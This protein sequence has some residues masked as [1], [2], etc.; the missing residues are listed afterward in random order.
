MADALRARCAPAARLPPVPE[1]PCGRGALRRARVARVV[2]GHAS[3]SP[4]GDELTARQQRA[5]VAR[6][7]RA[8]RLGARVGGAAAPLLHGPRCA[9]RELA[10]RPP[11]APAHFR[12]AARAARPHRACGHSSGSAPLRCVASLARRVVA[13][14]PPPAVLLAASLGSAAYGA[15][16]LA[17]VA[18]LDGALSATLVATVVRHPRHVNRT[19]PPLPYTH[20]LCAVKHIVGLSHRTALALR[21]R[22]SPARASAAP[23]P[24]ARPARRRRFSARSTSP[25]P[26]RS[27]SPS[28]PTRRTGCCRRRAA[29]APVPPAAVPSRPAVP[30]TRAP[31]CPAR[32]CASVDQ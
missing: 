19:H 18:A 27:H 11:G 32:T 9:G 15:A 2:P 24:P 31:P 13:Q 1:R 7:Q 17:L 26:P 4:W 16:T 6:A 8:Q 29:P 5:H 30:A 28:T 22:R 3:R 25:P 21:A 10:R 20:T 14:L 23:H 12:A